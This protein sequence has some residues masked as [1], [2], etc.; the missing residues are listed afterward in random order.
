MIRDLVQ[1]EDPRKPY[2]D[3]EIVKIL[4]TKGVNIARRTITKYREML[5]VLSSSKRKKHI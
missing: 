3:Q 5:G 2:S 4:K 1:N